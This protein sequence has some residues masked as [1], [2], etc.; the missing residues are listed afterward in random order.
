MGTS[1]QPRTANFTT[2][3]TRLSLDL[4]AL[5]VRC[6][7]SAFVLGF[8]LRLPA[9]P[10]YASRR[11]LIP[12]QITAPQPAEGGSTV[13]RKVARFDFNYR[14]VLTLQKRLIGTAC[15]TTAQCQALLPKSQCI[16]SSC[17]CIGG[18]YYSWKNNSCIPL[19][20]L[21]ENCTHD[22]ECSSHLM[23]SAQRCTCMP[24]Y[25]QVK[26]WCEP[27]QMQDDTERFMEFPQEQPNL[28]VVI[29]KGLGIIALKV[30][31]FYLLAKC[32]EEELEH[33]SCRLS[34]EEEEDG[35][36]SAA[37]RA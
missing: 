29:L 7:F 33:H 23:C 28:L 21:G 6:F 17:F 9:V 24:G 32:N 34:A 15:N 36:L 8:R 12:N 30:S 25:K 10:P 31:L 5:S 18:H 4:R 20:L 22:N 16:Y 26:D 19:M 1:Q 35:R 3:H 14:S 37:A 11:V 2:T 13:Q 27:T